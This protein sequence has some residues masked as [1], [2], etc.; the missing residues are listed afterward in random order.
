MKCVYCPRYCKVDRTKGQRGF[1]K[2]GARPKVAMAGLHYWEEPLISGT[3]GSGTVFFSHCNLSCLFCQNYVIS[4]EDRGGKEMEPEELAQLF[5]WLEKRGAHNIN[6]V[7]PTHYAGEIALAIRIAKSKGI[8]I[9]FVYNSNG[10]DSIEALKI[11]EGLI[12][13]YLPDLKYYSDSLAVKYSSAPSYFC[14]ASQA[15][16]EMSRQVGAVV[17]DEQG[18]VKRGLIVRHL[19]LP[20]ATLDSKKILRWVKQN[21]PRGTY[22]SLMA[23]YYPAYKAEEHEILN[24]KLT[25][26][27]YDEVLSELYELGFEH[28]YT[29]ELSAASPDY[30]PDFVSSAQN[31]GVMLS[32]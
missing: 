24:R 18:I 30:T 26:K 32:F 29:Q 19:V 27:E 14:H 9:P 7:S 1:C 17:L 16:L 13:V 15:I 31:H 3:K 10:Y 28:G 11:M 5:L 23:Q 12:D 8:S 20:G 25:Q 22:V 4:Q 6:L 2:A 21:L